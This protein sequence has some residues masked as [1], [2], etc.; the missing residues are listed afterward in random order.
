[1]RVPQHGRFVVV[2]VRVEGRAQGRV[3]VVVADAAAAGAI[4]GEAVVDRAEAGG[5]EGGEDARV[6]SDPFGG[7]LAA[8]EPGGDQVVGVAAVGL[9]AGRAP[10]G[11]AV[12]AAD[13]ELAG[14][15]GGGVQMV[16]HAADL[17][18]RPVHR[19]FGAVAVEAYRAG[20]AAQAGQLAAQLGQGAE[21]GRHGEF[22][23]R[24]RSLPGDDGSSFRLS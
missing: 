19:V 15:E 20:A 2:R 10:G 13:E 6:G 8:A 9:G 24:R 5:G 22:R 4:T 16:Q 3:L 23:Q 14:R 21:G 7:A 18:G 17:P 12:V 11:A 1:V